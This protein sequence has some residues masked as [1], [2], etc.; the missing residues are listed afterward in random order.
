MNKAYWDKVYAKKSSAQTSWTQSTPSPSIDWILECVPDRNGA[1]VDVGG[2]TSILVDHLLDAGYKLPAVMDISTA[3]LQQSKMRLGARKSLVEW[4]EGDVTAFTAPRPFALWHD[5]AV[6]HFLTDA[7]SR[8]QY[9]ESMRSSL[10]PNGKLI[11][12]TFSESGPNKCSGLEV[13]RYD[14]SSLVKEVG[15]GFEVARLERKTHETPWAT[16]QDFL[17]GLFTLK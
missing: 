10:L 8:K 3:A 4:I 2:G 13:M 9:F 1:V 16:E 12:A 14:E 17:Y 15:A 7:N 11:L 6:F 5:R